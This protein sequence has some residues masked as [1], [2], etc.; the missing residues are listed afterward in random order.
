M[1][2]TRAV[3]TYSFTTAATAAAAVLLLASAASAATPDAARSGPKTAGSGPAVTVSEAGQM[4]ITTASPEAKKLYLEGRDLVEKLRVTD[5]REKML[6]A[7]AKDPD[8]ALAYVGLAN[9]S[10]TNRDFFDAVAKAKA[11]AEHASAAERDVIAALDAGARGD[12]RTQRGLYTKVAAAFP[13]DPR[14]Q[15]LLG[16]NYFGQ[17]E[18]ERAI[19]CY[20]RAIKID[21]S[22]TTPYNQLGYAHRFLGRYDEAEKA[23]KR[24]IELIPNDPN[25]QDSYAELLMKTGRFEESIKT[26]EKALALDPNFTASAV[27]IANDQIFLGKGAA[28]RETLGKLQARARN[29]GEKRQAIFWTAITYVHEGDTEKA[30]AEIQ[31]ERA[32]ADEMKDV[33]A[34]SNDVNAI[35]TI[36]QAA[37][38]TDKAEASF[39]ESLALLEKADVPADVKAQ[40]RRHRLYEAAMSALVRA[41]LATARAKTE[42]FGKEVAAK[43]NPLEVLQHHELLGRVALGDKDF[44]RAVTELRAAGDQ[45][46]RVLLYLGMALEGQGDRDAAREAYRKAAE[47]NALNFNYAFVRKDAK[48]KLATA[49]A[50]KAAK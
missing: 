3:P 22:F 41:D 17:Q 13:G 37:G 20:N 21:P 25:P 1:P 26:Y 31:K 8:F 27:G 34:A 47:W 46:P 2:R 24:Y 12:A 45:D 7:V 43:G 49:V 30:I 16:A 38:A 15:M 23:F 35:A 5:A 29:P 11:H 44:A 33:G 28:A 4:P 39:D 40:G 32:V 18:Y 9:T 50:S 42:A 19:E 6:A 10:T 48:A 36:L 14:A